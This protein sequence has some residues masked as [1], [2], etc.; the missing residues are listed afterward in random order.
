[1][2]ELFN[3]LTATK[4]RMV[5]SVLVLS[6]L[7]ASTGYLVYLSV[8]LKGNLSFLKP[9]SNPNAASASCFLSL[10]LN[11]PPACNTT[12]LENT[13]C[14]SG[15][16]CYIPNTGGLKTSTVQTKGYCRN[17]ACVTNESCTC[18]P[19]TPPTTTPTASPTTTPTIIPTTTPTVA[20]TN[21]PTPTLS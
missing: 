21:T 1:M 11:I 18:G 17:A 20:P 3:K 10:S 19:T 15:Y 7:T 13:D 8:V 9:E 4:T 5:L 2:K 16:I 14:S 6:F 12:C